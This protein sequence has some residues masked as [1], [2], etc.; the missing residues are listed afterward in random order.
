[1]VCWDDE[2][3]QDIRGIGGLERL[4]GS[5]VLRIKLSVIAA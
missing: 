5:S 3:G 2:E 1:M 4:I